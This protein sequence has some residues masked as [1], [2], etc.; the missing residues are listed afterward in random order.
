[1]G[2]GLFTIVSIVRDGDAPDTWLSESLAA[3]GLLG[4]LLCLVGIGQWLHS[5]TRHV[6]EHRAPREHPYRIGFVV[7]FVGLAIVVLAGTTAGE[8]GDLSQTA[9]WIGTIGVCVCIIGLSI[10]GSRWS[11]SAIDRKLTRSLGGRPRLYPTAEEEQILRHL[12]TEQLRRTYSGSRGPQGAAAAQT[13]IAF[14]PRN[15]TD[16]RE[17]GCTFQVDLETAQDRARAALASAGASVLTDD[18]N[19]LRGWW[20]VGGDWNGAPAIVTF[21][22]A[23]YA[24]G[25]TLVTIRVLSKYWLTN[26]HIAPTVLDEMLAGLGLQPIPAMPPPGANVPR[27]G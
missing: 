13:A 27:R 8:N 18:G 15:P 6:L 23:S 26:Q 2:I 25:A 10:S 17:A 4:L 11:S 7:A 12:C 1:M 21:S 9:G 3:I 16:V 19:M 24:P 14:V 20:Q 5:L 22:F